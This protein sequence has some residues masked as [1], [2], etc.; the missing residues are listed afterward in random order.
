MYRLMNFYINDLLGTIELERDI[1]PYARLTEQFPKVNVAEDHAFQQLYKR[2]WQLNAARLGDRYIDS[3]F[4]LLQS[5]KRCKN[6]DIETIAT[7]LY[8][9]PNDRNERKLQFSFSTKLV[10][11]VRPHKPIYDSNVVAFFFLREGSETAATNTKLKHRL[12][13]YKYLEDEYGRILA[14]DLLGNAI[15]E[16]RTRFDPD[17][18]FTDEKVIDTL[19]WR[20]VTVLRSGTIRY[21]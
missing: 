7:Q 18:V 19:I 11:T 2:Y 6:L 10:H 1:R 4:E 14:Q 20:F 8:Q 13:S 5:S 12:A 21:R 3:Y 16:F 17:H 9:V 15:S